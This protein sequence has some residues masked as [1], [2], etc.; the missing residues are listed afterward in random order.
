[1]TNIDSVRTPVKMFRLIRNEKRR[2]REK[3]D[4]LTK[5]HM[6][7]KGE[8]TETETVFFPFFVMENTDFYSLSGFLALKSA[9]GKS[10]TNSKFWKR[11]F[12]ALSWIISTRRYW[13]VLNETIGSLDLFNC[14]RDLIKERKHPI[15]RIPLSRSALSLNQCEDCVFI[16]L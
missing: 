8:H 13:C 2:M 16:I 3:I 9:G 6:Y 10:K 12:L 5:R 1:M 15:D 11:R 4:R 7:I 14:E